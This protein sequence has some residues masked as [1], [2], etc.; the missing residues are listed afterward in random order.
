MV[1]LAELSDLSAE[2]LIEEIE[3]DQAEVEEN[4]EWETDSEDE[5][6]TLIER[7]LALRDII[8]PTFIT[9][10]T[11]KVKSIFKFTGKLAWLLSTTLFVFALPA[12]LELEREYMTV[13]QEISMRQ[14]TSAP[15]PQLQFESDGD[16]V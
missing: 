5:G 8:P 6:E 4:Q 9:N 1:Q 11:Y 14:P 7:I 13:Q 16:Q 2:K 15:Q 12:S 3:K 10:T